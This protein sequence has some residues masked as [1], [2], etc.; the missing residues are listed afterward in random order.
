MEK[1][2]WNRAAADSTGQQKY[3][4]DHAS[5]YVAKERAKVRMFSAATKEIIA[6]LKSMI[7]AG[8]TLAIPEFISR[9]KIRQETGLFE[10]SD[11]S[12]LGKVA[13]APGVYLSE[14]NG[15]HY[16]VWI[17]RILPPGPKTFSEARPAVISDYQTYLEQQWIAV[18]KKKHK[19]KMN[20][21]GLQYVA[22]QL[23]SG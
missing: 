15:L 13:W 22:R 20:K 2:V 19:V 4:K 17:K 11:R 21:K 16:V 23:K 8:D 6:Q 14:N 10:K 12:V 7:E 9:E 3:Y 1:E 5:D 18:L